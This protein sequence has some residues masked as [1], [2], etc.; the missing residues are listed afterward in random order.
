[1]SHDTVTVWSH[2]ITVTVTRSYDTKK[3]IENFGTNNIIQHS[4][5]IL[6]L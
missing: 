2:N 4:K 5:D 1:M 3:V 6:V